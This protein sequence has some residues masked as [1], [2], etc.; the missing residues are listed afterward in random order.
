[1]EAGIASWAIR[2][3]RYSW[4]AMESGIDAE[5]MAGRLKEPK[6]VRASRTRKA[7]YVAT[8]IRVRPIER[9][10]LEVEVEVVLEVEVDA[11]VDVGL[12]GVVLFVVGT[13][14]L[15]WP[16]NWANF[17]SFQMPTEEL[18]MNVDAKVVMPAIA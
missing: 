5:T 13:E 18:T 9:A 8:G 3:L 15:L 1:M 7:E 16:N 4:E 10:V 6:I 2:I 14:V 12:G 17:T 11:G